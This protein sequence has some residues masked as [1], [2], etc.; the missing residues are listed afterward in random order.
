MKQLTGAALPLM[1]LAMLAASSA[2]AAD[3]NIH[4]DR[5]PVLWTGI[6]AGLHGG[7]SQFEADTTFEPTIETPFFS[8]SSSR[9]TSSDEDAM[10]WGGQIGYL[11][12]FD[13]LVAGVE[14]DYSL[15]EFDDADDVDISN[16][17]LRA[18]LGLPIENVLLYGTAG[19]GWTEFDNEETL[20]AFTVGGGLELSLGRELSGLSVG[21]EGLYSIYEDYEEENAFGVFQTELDSF[22][23]RGK[24]N[25]RLPIQ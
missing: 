14:A 24:I 15:F 3:N 1:L 25:Y 17:S 9:S 12:Q 8:I 21:V 23:I 18:R 22:T 20:R 19:I 5:S 6:Y 13:W 4:R 7:Q 2:R 10:I 16:I 11:H